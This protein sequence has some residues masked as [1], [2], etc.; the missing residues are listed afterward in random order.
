MP[1]Q[2]TTSHACTGHQAVNHCSYPGSRW[3]FIL[4][5]KIARYC[6]PVRDCRKNIQ[7]VQQGK[8]PHLETLQMPPDGYDVVPAFT[9][10]CFCVASILLTLNIR[11][12]VALTLKL[13]LL[14]V[15]FGPDTSSSR[16]APKSLTLT[17]RFPFRSA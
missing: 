10:R 16:P 2:D 13:L 11:G 7:R 5:K 1:A 3:P 9:K 14:L 17:F 15:D 8:Q 4:G 12:A 6:Y